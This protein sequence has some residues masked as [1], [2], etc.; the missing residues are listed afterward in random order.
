VLA[1]EL[2]ALELRSLDRWLGGVHLRSG[3]RLWRWD[4]AERLL[5]AER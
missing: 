2:D 4:P 5:R 1:R 3:R